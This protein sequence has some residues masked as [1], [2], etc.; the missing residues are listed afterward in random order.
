M[1][2]YERRLVALWL[3]ARA[4]VYS[5]NEA[6]KYDLLHSAYLLDE[7]EG[8]YSPQPFINAEDRAHFADWMQHSPHR[9]EFEQAIE[10]L[11]RTDFSSEL[12]NPYD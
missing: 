3:R 11:T 6:E 5:D 1:T 8:G 10:E 2:W 7:D 12:A 4:K 9:E